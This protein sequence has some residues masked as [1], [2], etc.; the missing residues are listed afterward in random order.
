MRGI[1]F[2]AL[3]T[4]LLFL[5][6]PSAL[7]APEGGVDV[8][9]ADRCDFLDPAHCLY[10]FPNDHFTTGSGKDR[11]LNL[12]ADSMPANVTGKRID[13]SAWNRNDGFSPGQLII[14]KVPGLDTPE[15][16]KRTR[17]V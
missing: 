10:P 13:P 11:R 8:S 7:S 5:A 3:A 12:H 17:A 2:L 1:R 14:T 15:A 9:N 16:F 6:V 4:C